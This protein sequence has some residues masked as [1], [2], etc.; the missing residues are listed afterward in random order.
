MTRK[1][2]AN[3]CM[4]GRWLRGLIS[5]F[6]KPESLGQRGERLAERMYRDQGCTILARNWRHGQDELDLVVLD[7]VVLVFVEVK[8]RSVDWG[9]V[10]YR[11]VD[12]RKKTALRRA[13]IGW[14]RQISPVP[15]RRFDIVE[16]LV[17]QEGNVRLLQ[18]K[19][20]PLFRKHHT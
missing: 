20:V 2:E 8:T 11:A 18:H 17:C 10:G 13:A 15:H 14:L 4:I 1:L 5:R 3:E 16:V 9:G 19:G 12:K 6:R 7:G